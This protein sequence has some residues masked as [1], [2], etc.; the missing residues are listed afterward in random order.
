MAKKLDEIAKKIQ[1]K[2]KL[3]WNRQIV[4]ENQIIDMWYVLM[5]YFVSNMWMNVEIWSTTTKFY[6]A[7]MALL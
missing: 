5:W 3:V 6:I 4:N 2:K 7:T 1:T